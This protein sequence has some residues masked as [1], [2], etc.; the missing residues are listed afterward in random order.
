[1]EMQIPSAGVKTRQICYNSFTMQTITIPYS[2]LRKLESRIERLE[3]FVLQ[4]YHIVADRPKAP[5][6][7]HALDLLVGLGKKLEPEVEK[8]GLTEE[9]LIKD[10]R[11]TRKEIFKAVYGDIAQ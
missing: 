2:Y 6:S 5:S 3:Q 7:S 1:M 4:R 10:L 11:K 8:Q 9:Q